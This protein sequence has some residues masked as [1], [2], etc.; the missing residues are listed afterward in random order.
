MRVDSKWISRANLPFVS[1][2]S[3]LFLYFTNAIINNKDREDFENHERKF[4]L[5]LIYTSLFSFILSK[6][7]SI[8]DKFVVEKEK[9]VRRERVNVKGKLVRDIDFESM[10]ISR[11]SRKEK[12]AL[13]TGFKTVSRAFERK[14][15][16][17]W[18]EWARRIVSTAVILRASAG[19]KLDGASFAPV[20][21]HCSFG[22]LQTVCADSMLSIVFFSI[23]V[24]SS[25]RI[26]FSIAKVSPF[27][28]KKRGK[29]VF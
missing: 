25:L 6:H 19:H 2:R 18:K 28:R 21:D 26:F 16:A 7:L 14:M 22:C 3:L 27:R 9:D 10:I 13:S 23:D 8:F 12:F 24:V 20:I 29:R 1:T 17:V 15:R 5:Q 4:S 11:Y